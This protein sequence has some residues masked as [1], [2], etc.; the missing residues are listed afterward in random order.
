MAKSLKELREAVGTATA[1][2]SAPRR[3]PPQRFSKSTLGGSDLKR[4]TGAQKAGNQQRTPN[5]YEEIVKK[6]KE[7]MPAGKT[8]TNMPAETVDTNVNMS[9]TNGY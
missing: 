8:A 1:I 2:G 6:V 5:I 9:P 4:R 3:T 7:K